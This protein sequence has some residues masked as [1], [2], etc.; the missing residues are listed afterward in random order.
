MTARYRVGELFQIETM[1]VWPVYDTEGNWHLDDGPMAYAPTKE[2]A[3]RIAAALNQAEAAK[4]LARMLELSIRYLYRA[5]SPDEPL[6]DGWRIRAVE[7][8]A[9][10]ALALL[11]E[12]P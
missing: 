6:P 8:R 12:G 9:R 5:G 3:D 7:K 10:D 11:G 4:G 2:D 1:W